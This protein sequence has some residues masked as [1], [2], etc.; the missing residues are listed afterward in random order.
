MD[1]NLR[2]LFRQNLPEA[3]WTSVETGSTAAGVP[4]A[5]FIFEGGCQGWVEFK[6]ARGRIVSLR[7][8]QVSWLVRR[9]RLGGRCFVAV[10]CDRDLRM[11]LGRHAAELRDQGTRLQAHATWGPSVG[12][13]WD[14]AAIKAVLTR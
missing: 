10:R 12:T 1:G 7:P 5:E 14:W 4:D 2:R 13:K 3:Q 8:E 6:A 11:Y 9:A